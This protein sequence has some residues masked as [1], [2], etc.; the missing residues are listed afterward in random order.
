[1]GVV[2]RAQE[3]RP[4]RRVALKV[5]AP[6]LAADPVF[7]E[8]F[9]REAELAASIEHSNV[10][11]LF[12]VGEE[13]GLL[14]LV[15]RYVDGTD[16]AA[17]IAAS[18]HL[19]PRRTVAIVSQ[20]CE[21]LDAAHA[22]GLVHRDVKPAN[23]LLATEGGR[24]HAYLADFGLTK[25]QDATGGPTKTGYFFGTL[26]YA[27]PEQFQGA[28]VDARTDVYAAG[29]LL[30][31]A[32]TGRVPFPADSAAA[33]MFAHLSTPPP[34]VRAADQTLPATLDPVV[35]KAMAKSPDDRYLSAGDLG[36]AATA[37]LEGESLTRAERSVAIGNAAAEAPTLAPPTPAET[38][39]VPAHAVAAEPT[40]APPTPAETD[41]VPVPD[42]AEAPTL[43]PP[44]PPTIAPPPDH[45][46]A[47]PPG[48]PAPERGHRRRR[49]LAAVVAVA[50]VAG[51]L[52]IFLLS[53]STGP[54]DPVYNR[55]LHSAGPPGLPE[56]Y[57]ADKPAR[58]GA[59]K[60]AVGA[61]YVYVHPPGVFKNTGGI[62]YT[63]TPSGAAARQFF[64]SD[65]VGDVTP[66]GF[67]VPVKCTP[68]YDK[69]P[70]DSFCYALAG[71][72]EIS[73]I[74]TR[75]G[76]TQ[77]NMDLATGLL[78]TA[79]QQAQAAQDGD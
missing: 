65:S 40:L 32:L 42:V 29:C 54:T 28:R 1:M 52:A 67:S 66:A 70:Q 72:V 21:A 24:E 36:R 8:R 11:P 73:V 51:G 20:V 68:V 25:R 48:P 49:I 58:S 59:S 55:L 6:D 22:R 35:A 74:A 62:T 61:V 18:G 47:E 9:E 4:P 31:H 44:A 39:D 12:R 46:A 63:V 17:L 64:P 34:S 79:V 43:A 69:D 41:A 45:T 16:L 57:V 56:N 33:G 71:R 60:P 76:S 3:R 78:R 30:Y 77:G 19:E 10:L 13:G 5:I 37:A 14:Y 38:A 50:V 27:A 75:A 7:R 15:T 26:D 2:Y 53:R 23:V